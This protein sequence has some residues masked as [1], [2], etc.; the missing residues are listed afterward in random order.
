MEIKR[1]VPEKI[2]VHE[3][4][5]P[6][7][8]VKF[9]YSIEYMQTDMFIQKAIA[10]IKNNINDYIICSGY[11]DST[12]FNASVSDDFYNDFSNAMKQ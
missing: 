11:S 6:E 4:S 9:P 2:Y 10:F 12:D 3:M 1:D 5:A 7:L 8:D